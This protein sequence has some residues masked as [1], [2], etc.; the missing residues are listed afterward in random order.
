[1]VT[2]LILDNISLTEIREETQK[3]LNQHKLLILMWFSGLQYFY[4]KEVV[5]CS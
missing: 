3:C 1:M 5:Y 4:W 2:E